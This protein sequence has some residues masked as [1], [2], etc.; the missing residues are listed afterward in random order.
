MAVAGA[1]G[2]NALAG[3]ALNS[4]VGRANNNK[5]TKEA[6]GAAKYGSRQDYINAKSDKAY[7]K[8]EEH[9]DEYEKYFKNGQ[10]AMSKEEFNKAT[11]E[12]RKV[13]ITDTKTIRKALHLE[14]M[15]AKDNKNAKEVREKV[16][17]IAQSYDA[18]DRK[19]VYGSDD[20]A[21]Q[22]TLKNIQG[23]LSSGD[24]KQKKAI[25]NEILQ[26]YRDWYNTP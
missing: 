10:Y 22:A 9:N 3:R 8:S 17:N 5:S 6:F 14:A 23:Q 4:T 19:A 15:Y 20:R 1:T 11:L 24:A 25:A 18:I 13:G 7:L 12:Y 26:G 2:G 21:T 16:Q